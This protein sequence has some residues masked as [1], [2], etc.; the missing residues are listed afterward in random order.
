MGLQEE[1]SMTTYHYSTPKTHKSLSGFDRVKVDPGQTNFFLGRQF[2]AFKEFSIPTGTS[3]VIQVVPTI[4]VILMDAHINIDNGWLKIDTVAGGTPGGTF[5][6]E[7]TIFNLNNMPVG[8]DKAEAYAATATVSSGGTVTGGVLL[9]TIRL[10]VANNSNFGASVNSAEDLP[11]GVSPGTY[12]YVL[13]NLGPD[14]A[15]GVWRIAWEDRPQ[16]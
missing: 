13:Q 3:L 1:G 16:S 11:R 2:R 5:T 15:T 10:K 8:L 6:P 12:Y 7:S 14:T 4:P 9:D